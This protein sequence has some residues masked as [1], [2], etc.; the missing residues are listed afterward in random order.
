[1]ILLGNNMLL[2]TF[3]EI[4]T[5]AIQFALPLRRSRKRVCVITSHH[6]PN[7]YVFA[8]AFSS[9]CSNAIAFLL[10]VRLLFTSNVFD[11]RSLHSP[12]LRALSL[13]YNFQ[14]IVRVVFANAEGLHKPLQILHSMVDKMQKSH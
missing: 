6:Q 5:I 13:I 1:M 4:N 9:I 11:T 8:S 12:Y 7:K 10:C 14:E 3:N 2:L